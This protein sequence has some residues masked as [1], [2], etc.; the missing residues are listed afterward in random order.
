M[1]RRLFYGKELGTK[2]KNVFDLGP[3]TKIDALVRIHTGYN[4][5]S[6]MAK[7]YPTLRAPPG[8]NSKTKKE[9]AKLRKA[10]KLVTGKNAFKY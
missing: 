5:L 8:S 1:S 4:S 7:N 9:F 10:Y 3:Q 6:Q 2:E